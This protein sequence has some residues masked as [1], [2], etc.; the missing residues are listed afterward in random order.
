VFIVTYFSLS[1]L[2]AGQFGI[3]TIPAAMGIAQ[4]L[5]LATFATFSWMLLKDNGQT[6]RV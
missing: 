2:M 3:Y 5:N 4:V 1:L 6:V